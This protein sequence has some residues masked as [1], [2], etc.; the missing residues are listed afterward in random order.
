MVYYNSEIEVIDIV[1]Q[2]AVGWYVST[3]TLP[4]KNHNETPD[5]H[6]LQHL[7]TSMKN[8]RTFVATEL[9]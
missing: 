6:L 1:I 3:H 2:L 5:V 8:S 4:T 9:Q 7:K